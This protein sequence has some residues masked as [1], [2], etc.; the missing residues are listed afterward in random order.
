MYFHLNVQKFKKI[1]EFGNTA[2]DIFIPV[3]IPPILV[4]FSSF[5]YKSS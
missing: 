4:N 2:L 3:A 1:Y 5:Y